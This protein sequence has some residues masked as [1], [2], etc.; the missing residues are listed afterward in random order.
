MTGGAAFTGMKAVFEVNPPLLVTLILAVVPGVVSKPLLSFSGIRKLISE[1]FQLTIWSCAEF[2]GAPQ[3][4][5]S[6]KNWR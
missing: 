5:P 3:L 2:P 4:V 6:S 1:S